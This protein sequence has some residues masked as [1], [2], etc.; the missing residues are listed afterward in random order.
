MLA[1]VPLAGLAIVLLLGFVG[2]TQDFDQFNPNYVTNVEAIP[3][4]VSYWPLWEG[5]SDQPASDQVGGHD[6]VYKTHADPGDP[7]LATAPTPGTIEF[8]QP[9][10][11]GPSGG[12]DGSIRVD[13]GYVEVPFVDALNTATFSFIAW[14]RAGWT[15]ADTGFYRCVLASREATDTVKRG[16]MLYA[17]P[18]NKWEAWIGDGANWQQATSINPIALDKNELLSVTYDGTTLK[19]YVDNEETASATVAYAPSTANPLRIGDGA[20]EL[21]D[22]L[23]PFVGLMGHVAYFNNALDAQT[24]TNILLSASQ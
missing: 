6:G 20:P 22:P 5:S 9:S 15:E 14:V 19:L 16:F 17:N 2:C 3:S 13:G 8:H 18:D 4:I 1:F 11:I 24:I 10:L 12:D 7:A 23:F 21:P